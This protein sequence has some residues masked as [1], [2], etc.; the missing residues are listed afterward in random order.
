MHDDSPTIH[1]TEVILLLP[2]GKHNF[3]VDEMF[4]H[5]YQ[6][7]SH[8]IGYNIFSDCEFRKKWGEIRGSTTYSKVYSSMYIS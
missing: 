4:C 5:A 1:E 7:V 3:T 2:N 6:T 8:A